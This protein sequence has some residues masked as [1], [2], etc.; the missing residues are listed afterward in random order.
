VIHTLKKGET[1][2]TPLTGPELTADAL[3][4]ALWIDLMD[5]SD[6]EHEF[7]EKALDI[8][9][10]SREE[11][12]EIEESSRLFREDDTL[13]ISCWLLCY[14]SP[15][16]ANA[17]VTFIVTK[18]QFMSIRH[19]DHHAFRVFMDT[20]K[21]KH[22]RK[23]RD[24]GDVY[25]ELMDSMTNHIAYTLRL[26]EQDLN[27]LSIEIFAEQKGHVSKSKQIGLKRVV[28]RLGKRNSL[29]SNLRESSVSL[30]TMT[31]FFTANAS[32]WMEPHVATRLT[33]LQRDVK[34]LGEYNTQLSSEIA[35]LLDSTVGLINFEQNQMMKWLGAA[36]LLVTFI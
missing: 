28:K 26:V 23:F 17:S 33:T 19:T 27:E 15:I 6:E 11:M 9:I 22:S 20:R 8:S 1:S 10:P 24:S 5:S 18:D 36:A 14:D 3:K 31:P 21:R 4:E 25:A 7:I 2:L 12:L 34:S 13:F 35:F 32:E 30:S 29:V 16:P